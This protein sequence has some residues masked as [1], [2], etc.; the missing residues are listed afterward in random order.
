MQ[1]YFDTVQDANGR[2]V[3]GATVTVYTSGVANPLPV[4]YQ[5]TGSKT[6]PSVQNNPMTTDPLGNFGFAAPDGTY[7][8]VISGGG[9]PT[10][11]LAN[12]NFFDGGITYPSPML[13]TVTSVSLS[14][15]A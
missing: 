13:G 12:V 5:T 10:K 7:D 6:A 3:A 14:A 8:I 2:A 11:T 9:I 4:I 1:R 15:P